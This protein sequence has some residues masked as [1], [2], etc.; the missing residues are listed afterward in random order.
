MTRKEEEPPP[1]LPHSI[2]VEK[3][4]LGAAM[5]EPK[6]A[7]Y[8][9]HR[10]QKDD[11]FRRAHQTLFEAIRALRNDNVDIDLRTLSSKLGKKGL[12]DVGGPA[13][14]SSLLDGVPRSTNVDHYSDI[15]QDLKTKR[16]LVRFG[17]KVLEGVAGGDRTAHDLLVDID[18]S[19]LDM[20]QGFD[21]GHMASLR[22][23]SSALLANLEYRVEHK[24]QLS[25]VDT[26]FKS[27]NEVTNG[28]Q[29]GDY[30]VLG[31]RPS[32]GKTTLAIN[33]A[34]AGAATG[35]HVAFF[36][37]EMTRQQLEFRI[38]SS[39][40]R[41]PLTRLL[42]G[43]VFEGEWTPLSQATSTMGELSIEIDDAP[44]RTAWD[45]RGACRRLKAEKGLDL[46]V[47]D[48]VQLMPGT[49][50]RK[51]S[52]RN[53]EMTDIS[54]RLKI[55]AGEARIAIILL[56][57]LSRAGDGRSDP[58]PKLSDLRDSGALEQD[59]D[60][61]AFL[62]RKNH[63]EGGVTQFIIEKQRNGPTGTVNLTLD[64]DITLFTDGGEDP[65]P[66]EKTDEEKQAAKTRAIIRNRRA[67]G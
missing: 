18:R 33:T 17:Q 36:S 10:L 54:R 45:I 41:V 64:R 4:T 1:L 58:R 42:S 15:L 47:I 65:A 26:G 63:R 59:A 29:A 51:G 21:A 66:V 24:G 50:D 25:G 30:I 55:L 23:T 5:L 39:L 56:S 31:A 38:L 19:V 3:S 60:I 12:D 14:L 46:A 13:Y 35:K 9:V 57:Q 7:D 32:I 67:A 61:V 49:L 62:H 28:W 48:Y 16:A 6:A 2:E 40:S 37:M 22:D 27:I 43:Y 52:T 53:D 44:A 8:L 34:M 11:Y 20:Q